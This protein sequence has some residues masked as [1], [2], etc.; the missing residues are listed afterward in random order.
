MVPGFHQILKEVCGFKAAHFAEAE[1]ETQKGVMS[2]SPLPTTVGVCQQTLVGH[3]SE[4]MG[5]GSG[6]RSLTC[7]DPFCSALFLGAGEGFP[8]SISKGGVEAQRSRFEDA[9]GSNIY[10]VVECHTRAKQSNLSVGRSA[11]TMGKWEFLTSPTEKVLKTD[12][13]LM[14]RAP[15]HLCCSGCVPSPL[16]R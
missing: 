2:S 8:A 13:A 14:T 1:T 7:K 11:L 6:P 12:K 5:V 3:V 15:G 4:V 9:H 10:T 16:L